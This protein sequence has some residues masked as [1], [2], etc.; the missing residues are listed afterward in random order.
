MPE[1]PWSV[2]AST[3]PNSVSHQ[4]IIILLYLALSGYYLLKR[5]PSEYRVLSFLQSSSL[6]SSVFAGSTGF[7][8]TGIGG[9]T[10]HLNLQNPLF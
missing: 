4:P 8:L 6:E 3:L 5:L 10:P 1:T 2:A 7:E 9:S